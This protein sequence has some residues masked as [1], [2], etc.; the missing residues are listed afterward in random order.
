M[1]V[2][3][4]VWD[5]PATKELAAGDS[6]VTPGSLDQVKDWVSTDTL[7]FGGG[8]TASVDGADYLEITTPDYA[9]GLAAANAQLA[10]GVVNYVAVQIGTDVVVFADV[11]GTNSASDGVVLVGRTLADISGSNI[12]H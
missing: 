12:I 4:N 1:G 9:S 5:V 11:A 3:W 7:A 6:G 8:A 2:I 10:G